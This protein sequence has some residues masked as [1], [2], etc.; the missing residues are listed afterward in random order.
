MQGHF[1]HSQMAI[2]ILSK[3][4]QKLVRFEQIII[5]RGASSRWSIGP[6]SACCSVEKTTI[7]KTRPTLQASDKYEL[8][9]GPFDVLM[10]CKKLL[11]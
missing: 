10:G 7:G 6:N 1:Q 2:K 5:K 11:V 8:T 9:I 4:G 3:N